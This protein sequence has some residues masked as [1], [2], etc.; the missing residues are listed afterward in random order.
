MVKTFRIVSII[1]LILAALPVL[2]QSV[3]AAELADADG[4]FIT[5]EGASLYV[6]DRGDP[7]HPA[8]LLLH[9][10]GGSTFS[11]RFTI[12]PLVAAGY[13]VVAFDRPPYGL[14][15]KSTDLEYTSAAY[16]AQTVGL[17]DVLGIEQAALIG[18]SAGGG[19]ITAVALAHPE[20][21]TALV[22]AAGAVRV[23]GV[24]SFAP[25]TGDQA[26]PDSQQGS[27]FG[28]LFEVA[29]QIDPASPLARLLVRQLVT[30]DMLADVVYGNY[31]DESLVTA[32]VIEGYTQ[33]LRVDGWEGAFLKLLT[34]PMGGGVEPDLT[35]LQSFDRPVLLQWGEND[36]VVP[37]YVGEA[38]HAY[39]EGSTLIVYPETGHLPM[40][41]RAEAFN[42]DLLA[43][44]GDN[45]RE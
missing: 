10:F 45:L 9:G 7:A 18:H 40:E 31:Y 43:W 3:P 6:I 32:D 5:V 33:I 23:P 16:T 11:W 4:Q 35:P 12:D 1:M 27:V 15:D 28:S 2:A 17:M 8:V 36:G 13:R 39:V 26:R 29:G 19:V 42:A 41:E 37:L 20:R 30:P 44:L 25:R 24:E 21:V 38:L 34:L 22:F 14:A